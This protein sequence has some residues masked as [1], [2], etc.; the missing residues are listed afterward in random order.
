[1]YVYPAKELGHD[2]IDSLNE[3][4]FVR[5]CIFHLA[6]LYFEQSVDFN[7]ISEIPL[8]LMH[9]SFGNPKIELI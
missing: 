9:I 8:E 5:S 2:I 6:N 4:K 7:R 1:L 3:P